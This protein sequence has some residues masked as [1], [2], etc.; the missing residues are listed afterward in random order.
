MVRTKK[1]HH[2]SFKYFKL[3]SF[4]LNSQIFKI[5]GNMVQKLYRKINYGL[6]IADLKIVHTVP[7]VIKMKVKY[8]HLNI[9]FVAS[10]R[11]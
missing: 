11:S 1:L 10:F 7:K 2:K 4:G 3:A 5:V 6:K 9:L 8:S